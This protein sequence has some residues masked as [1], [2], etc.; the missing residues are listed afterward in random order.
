VRGDRYELNA[1]HDTRIMWLLGYLQVS[2]VRES[3]GAFL[4]PPGGVTDLPSVTLNF[5]WPDA[6]GREGGDFCCGEGK[7]AWRRA[8]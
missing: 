5:S 7:S 1:A 3:R 2:T 6:K 8:S 4:P